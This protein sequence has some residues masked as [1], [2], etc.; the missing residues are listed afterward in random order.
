MQLKQKIIII[1]D[2][3]TV[4]ES[5]PIKSLFKSKGNNDVSDDDWEQSFIL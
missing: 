1:T 4:T 3:D 5:N 2:F